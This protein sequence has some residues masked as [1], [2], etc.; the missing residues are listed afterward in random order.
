[1]VRACEGNGEG[2]SDG[3]NES[4]GE[5]EEEG[6]VQVQILS[7]TDVGV[8]G[9]NGAQPVVAEVDRVKCGEDGVRDEGAEFDAHCLNTRGKKRVGREGKRERRE[10]KN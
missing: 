6:G 10:R 1:M 9:G 3:A 2:E 8:A 7:D 5:G 4:E